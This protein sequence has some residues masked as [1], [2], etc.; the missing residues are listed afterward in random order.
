MK[1]LPICGSEKN[2][3]EKVF[4]IVKHYY[5]ALLKLDNNPNNVTEF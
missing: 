2:E 4:N 5:S 3:E 1:A